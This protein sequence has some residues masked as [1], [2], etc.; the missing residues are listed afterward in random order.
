M[1]KHWLLVLIGLVTIPL[2]LGLFGRYNWFLD[3]F[4]HFRVY[5][6]I[7]F[8]LVGLLALILKKW[9]EGG[10]SLVLS[11]ILFLTFAD[12]YISNKIGGTE[13]GLKITSINLFASNTEFEKLN[14]YV[15][16]EEFDIIFF[17]ELTHQWSSELEELKKVYPYHF[18][19]PRNG[20]FGIGVLSKYEFQELE[21]IDLVASSYP[22]IAIDV[23]YKKE[24]LS[25]IN[26]H[27]PPPI[28]QGLYR[29]RNFQFERINDLISKSSQE[30]VL[31]GDLNSTRFSPNFSLLFENG[32]LRDSRE[33]FG[34]LPTWHAQFPLISVTLDHALV[35]DGLEVL[36]RRVGPEIGSDHLPVII[37]VGWNQ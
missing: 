10:F 36:N 3:V 29:T 20:S 16:E 11:L 17:Q 8:L 12:L 32:K 37:E 31:I 2:I 9:K 13:I 7:A 25:I 18:F 19:L 4:S 22:S 26:T 15:S 14:L 5:Y 23:S 34:L 28:T 6:C 35:T 30:V 27:P 1:K 21:I 33:G 24:I